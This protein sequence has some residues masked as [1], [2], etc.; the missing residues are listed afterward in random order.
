MITHYIYHIPGRKVGCTKD[1]KTREWDYKSKEGTIP[2]MEVLEEVH[3]ANDQEAGD[4]EWW[5]AD[6][7]GYPRSHHYTHTLRITS[8]ITPE[9]R[10]I[11][12]HKAGTK[13]M[14]NLTQEGRRELATKASRAALISPNRKPPPKL[15]FE[16][17]SD[18]S[19]KTTQR[20]VAEGHHTLQPTEC[21]HCGTKGGF[22][23]LQRWHFNRCRK[24]K[25][26]RNGIK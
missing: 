4:R 15:S 10:S 5:W 17:A 2:T 1:L 26:I 16:Q 13:R 22:L 3:D 6:K 21:P 18:R 11:R 23:A 25:G 19:S 14:N 8:G 7:L 24:L 20:M 12:G 9:Q